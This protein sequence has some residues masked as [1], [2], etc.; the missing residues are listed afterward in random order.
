M[1]H[2]STVKTELRDRESLLA[3]LRDL[4]QEPSSGEQP[5]RGYRGQTVTAD[6]CCPQSEGGDIGF[7]WNSAEQRYELVTDLDLWKQSVP[8]ERFLAQLTQRYALQSIL[9]SSA[10]E[11]YQV[12]EQRQQADG[13]IE[14][15]VTRWQG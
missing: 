7:R 14:L 4:G 9:R 5:V 10:E 3:A 15:V 2:F 1:S 8:V 6:L 11:G 12:A 13:S